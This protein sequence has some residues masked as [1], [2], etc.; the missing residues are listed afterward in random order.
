MNVSIGNTEPIN[1]TIDEQHLKGG[2]VNLYQIDVNKTETHLSTWKL[3]RG[4]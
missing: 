1:W 3:I 2:H 4:K